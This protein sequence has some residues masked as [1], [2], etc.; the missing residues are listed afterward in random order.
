MY[1]S[2]QSWKGKK[3]QHNIPI[4]L[5]VA[6]KEPDRISIIDVIKTISVVMTIYKE[7]GTLTFL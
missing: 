2:F 3:N 4:L 5:I 7:N 6:L 1:N